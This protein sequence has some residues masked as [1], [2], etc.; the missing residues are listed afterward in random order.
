MS[1][2]G[3]LLICPKQLLILR[4]QTTQPFQ[5][6]NITVPD[7][8]FSELRQVTAYGIPGITPLRTNYTIF[9]FI[10]EAVSPFLETSLAIINATA[11]LEI[12]CVEYT[13]SVVMSVDPSLRAAINIINIHGKSI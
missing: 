13:G 6:W 9:N 11:D 10:R 12:S 2:S 5:Q 7:F 4:C 3:I 1:P 8:R